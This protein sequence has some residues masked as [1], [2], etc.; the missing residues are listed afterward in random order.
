[1]RSIMRIG[2]APSL[3]RR[4]LPGDLLGRLTGP[5]WREYQVQIGHLLIGLFIRRLPLL[6]FV[7]V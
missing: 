2:T 3:S 6:L 1:M 7:H 5:T 4:R